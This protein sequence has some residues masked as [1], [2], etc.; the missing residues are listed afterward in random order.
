MKKLALIAALASI[1]NLPIV[2]NA[3]T[4]S[5]AF[6]VTVAFTPSCT[7]TASTNN[8]AFTY[9][10]F[11]AAPAAVTVSAPIVLTCSRGIGAVATAAY[12]EGGAASGLIGPT[13]LRYTLSVPA[14]TNTPGT[15]ATG[16]TGGTIGTA[17]SVS[18]S[19]TGTLPQQAG[20]GT[21]AAPVVNA[22][23]ARTLVVTF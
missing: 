20:A 16:T 19:F 9:T 15:A 6:N 10:A 1:V 12:G 14:K 13:N 22:T 11:A 18:F 8:I 21:A 7:V 4:V 5:G 2:A 3:A 23:D 17:D